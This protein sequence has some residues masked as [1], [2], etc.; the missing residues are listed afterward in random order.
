MLIFVA[1]L[2]TSANV[3]VLMR[4]TYLIIGALPRHAVTYMF[5]CGFFPGSIHDTMQFL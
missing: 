2:V 1:D 3:L 5:V 4:P